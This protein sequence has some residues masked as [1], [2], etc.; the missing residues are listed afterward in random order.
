MEKVINLRNGFTN[1]KAVV[2][3]YLP[4]LDYG[5]EGHFGNGYGYECGGGFGSGFGYGDGT[6]LKNQPVIGIHP[7]E[8]IWSEE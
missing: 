6:A 8:W 7:K 3:D 5:N 2:E 1:L 4:Y